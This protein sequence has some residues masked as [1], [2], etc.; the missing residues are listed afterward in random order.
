M[1]IFC[2]PSETLNHIYAAY[3]AKQWAVSSGG[4][5]EAFRISLIAKMRG[6]SP[7]DLGFLYCVEDKKLHLPFTF[8]TRPKPSIEYSPVWQSEW[9]GNFT[10][11]PWL[12]TSD[13]GMSVD[14]IPFIMPTIKR[15]INSRPESESG[16]PTSWSNYLRVSG[17]EA[18]NPLKFVEI[19]DFVRMVIYL[20]LAI[21]Q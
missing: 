14:I 11:I 15:Q 5:A 2:F 19:E 3:A 10:I 12:S 9:M 8:A 4:V 16:R 1:N 21:A 18:L 20:Q 6:V 7:G 17:V 13:A